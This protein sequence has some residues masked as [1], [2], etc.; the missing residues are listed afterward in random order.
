MKFKPIKPS[1]YPR[2]KQFFDHQKYDICEYSLDS[3]SVWSNSEYQLFHAV[4]DE[5]LII[6]AEFKIN[7]QNRHLMLPVSPTRSFTPKELY[8]LAQHLKF[9]NF[10][11]VPESYLHQHG[12]AQVKSYFSLAEQKKYHDYVY[13]TGDLAQLKGNKYSKKRNLIKQ[14]ERKYLDKGRVKTEGITSVFAPE[15]IEFLEKWCKERECDL[16]KED[17]LELACEKEAAINALENIDILG[18]NGLLLRIDDVV[19]AF[20]IAARLTETMGALHFEKAYADVKGLYQYFD[21]LCA[22]H[23]FKEYQYINKESDMGIP[24][25]AKAKRSYHPVKMIKSYKLT[26]KPD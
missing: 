13:L 1:D 4:W 25:I 22:K 19:S 11:F 5:T 18:A 21:N 16:D 3:I 24:G 6:C 9:E 15:C 12:I 2:L 26:V 17:N 23:L 7:Q 14:F 10:W 8:D 20:G